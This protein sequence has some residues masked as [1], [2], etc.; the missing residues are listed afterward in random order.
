MAELRSTLQD[1]TFVDEAY[2][3]LLQ[4]GHGFGFKPTAEDIES[5][6]VRSIALIRE[7]RGPN[8]V[9]ERCPV[10]YLAYLSALRADPETLQRWLAESEEALASLGMVIFVPIEQPDRIDV[11]AEDLPKLRGRV[12]RVL[13]EV[14]LDD[15]WN[16]GLTVES[17]E[18]PPAHRA[19]QILRLIGVPTSS[20]R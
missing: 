17:V 4:E 3:Y 16:L 13:G 7:A 6:L 12:D 5:Q 18:G 19:S 20:A 10:D 8:V 15:S 2:T 14:L 11:S 1:Y 9:F